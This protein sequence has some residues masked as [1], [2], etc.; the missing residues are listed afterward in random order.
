MDL[1]I[2]VRYLETDDGAVGPA[3]PT[4][5]GDTQLSQNLPIGGVADSKGIPIE[6]L[7]AYP[8]AGRCRPWHNEQGIVARVGTGVCL[9]RASRGWRLFEG[10]GGGWQG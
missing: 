5:E 6:I 3:V 7:P 10:A 2:Y 9:G 1:P 4:V 8:Q